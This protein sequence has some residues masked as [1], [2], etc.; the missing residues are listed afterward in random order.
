MTGAQRITA[1]LLLAALIMLAFLAGSLTAVSGLASP[2]GIPGE[3][4]LTE[5]EWAAVQAGNAILVSGVN[6]VIHLPLIAR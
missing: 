4:N 6:T 2:A 5:A 1:Y 3:T